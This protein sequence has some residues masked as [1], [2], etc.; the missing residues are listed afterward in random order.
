MT[1]YKFS[2]T[3]SVDGL[4]HDN[5]I[6]IVKANSYKEAYAEVHENHAIIG[7]DTYIEPIE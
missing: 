4:G 6:V 5:E 1:E 7:G 3:T 2:V